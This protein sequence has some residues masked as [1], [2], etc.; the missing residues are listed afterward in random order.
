[1]T[2]S[3]EFLDLV[4]EQM[5]D[6]GCVTARSMFGAVG[7]YRGGV[8]FAL[9]ADDVLYLK[10]TPSNI[11]DFD[12]EGLEPF[13]YRREGKKTVMSYRR[14]PVRC[15]EGHDS[16]TEWCRKAWAAASEEPER[17]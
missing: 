17:G 1:L 11:P 6:F 7:I 3:R 14:A 4:L 9:I 15:L 13:T 5:A 8:M 12:A 10:A 16:M 2:A